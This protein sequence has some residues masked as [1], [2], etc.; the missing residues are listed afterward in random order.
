MG[1]PTPRIETKETTTQTEDNDLY[2]M[3]GKR[4]NEELDYYRKMNMRKI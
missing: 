1:K 2:E 3:M 4:F